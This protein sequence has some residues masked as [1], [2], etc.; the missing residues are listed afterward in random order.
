MYLNILG[1]GETIMK[2]CVAHAIIKAMENG[3]S[4]DQATIDTINEMTNKLNNTAGIY[5]NSNNLK[6]HTQYN[7]TGAITISKT[8]E[9]GIAFSSKRMAWA[10]RQGNEVHYGIER[11]Q[12]EKEPAE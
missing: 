6:C 11:G 5:T 10:Y 8:G 3:K 2:F 4:A 9:I 7:F 12:H 1:H